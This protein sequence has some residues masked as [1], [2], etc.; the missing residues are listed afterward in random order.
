M[1]DHFLGENGDGRSLLWRLVT[2]T[3]YG[4]EDCST[5]VSEAP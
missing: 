2:T 5:G 4:F 1:R 3:N